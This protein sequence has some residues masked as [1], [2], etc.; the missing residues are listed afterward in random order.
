M[1]LKCQKLVTDGIS[2]LRGANEQTVTFFKLIHAVNINTMFPS[3]F[4]LHHALLR[5]WKLDR[6][7]TGRG[8]RGDDGQQRAL[9]HSKKAAEWGTAARVECLNTSLMGT[10][11]QQL[12]FACIQ[13][14]QL[15]YLADFACARERVV[16]GPLWSF[17]QWP[18][19]QWSNTS[20]STKPQYVRP[21]CFACWP[22]QISSEL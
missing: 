17:M 21:Y 15:F 5:Q 6:D 16:I 3:C 14:P 11:K 4:L 18:S 10:K 7:R 20:L 22:S 2:D 19:F 12:H 9:R 13:S 8:E 1:S